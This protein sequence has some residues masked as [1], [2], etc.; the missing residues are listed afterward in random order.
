MSIDV[1]K[2]SLPYIQPYSVV[3]GDGNILGNYKTI[4]LAKEAAIAFKSMTSN[5]LS[6]RKLDKIESPMDALE[7]RM[8]KPDGDKPKRVL[9]RRVIIDN[10]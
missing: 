4:Q 5:K 2:N 7:K 6:T 1:R 9:K 8:A 10:D 3:D